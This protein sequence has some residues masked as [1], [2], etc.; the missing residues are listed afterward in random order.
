MS[1]ILKKL[2]TGTL[3]KTWNFDESNCNGQ[4]IAV[5]NS[6]GD[7]QPVIHVEARNCAEGTVDRVEIKKDKLEALGFTVI[8]TDKPKSKFVLNSVNS[9]ELNICSY[10]YPTRE[11]AY[12]AM[13]DDIILVSDYKDLDEILDA[14]SNDEC[15]IDENG[16]WIETRDGTCQWTIYEVLFG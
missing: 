6:N 8:I 2:M 9:N 16:A 7:Y 10:T 5:K 3:L 13:V 12:Q 11:R 1:G 15:G 14:A 4:T